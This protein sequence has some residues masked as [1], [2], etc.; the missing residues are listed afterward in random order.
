MKIPKLLYVVILVVLVV[1]GLNVISNS[2]TAGTSIITTT[3]NETFKTG[4]S[5]TVNIDW[6]KIP[7]TSKKCLNETTLQLHKEVF[8]NGNEFEYNQTM[9]CSQCNAEKA[10]CVQTP[11][12]IGLE[13]LFGL[14]ILIIA[15][16][17]IWWY[18]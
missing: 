11:Y 10:E 8:I 3:Y 1:Y 2:L 13:L 18:V 6:D 4:E 12:G 9:H 17:L 16:A 14:G 5:G 15:I 7:V